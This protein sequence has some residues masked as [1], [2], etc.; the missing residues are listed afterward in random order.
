V[1]VDVATEAGQLIGR[2]Q[3]RVESP[4]PPTGDIILPVPF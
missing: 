1:R 3:V 4:P 2:C